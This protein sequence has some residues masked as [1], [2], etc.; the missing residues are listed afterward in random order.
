M[1]EIKTDVDKLVALVREKKAVSIDAAAKI[2]ELDQKTVQSLAESLED[3]GILSIEYRFT[4]QFLINSSLQPQKKAG[5]G[6]EAA[7]PKPTRPL[8]PYESVKLRI[9]SVLSEIESDQQATIRI[10]REIDKIFKERNEIISMIERLLK[11]EAE[12]KKSMAFLMRKAELI[13]IMPG[14][15]DK[16]VKELEKQFLA[17]HKKKL[18]VESEIISLRKL[19]KI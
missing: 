6:S 16:R 4:K 12:I 2:L 5:A 8:S 9:R 18:S 15:K 14:S 19:I 17:L 10:K 11:E 7:K 1:P 13:N 3:S